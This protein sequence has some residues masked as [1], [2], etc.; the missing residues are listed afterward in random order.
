MDERNSN[1]VAR[2]RWAVI[3][4]VRIGGVAM[5]VIGLLILEGAIALPEPL[6]YALLAVGL[7]G[8]FLAPILLARRWRS[9]AE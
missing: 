5:T 8:A 7:I 4:A 2:N 6:A 9:S 3:S 1:N